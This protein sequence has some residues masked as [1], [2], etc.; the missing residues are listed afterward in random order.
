[1]NWFQLRASFTALRT[2]N[3]S[4][5]RLVACAMLLASACATT[6]AQAQLVDPF[7]WM[8][9][10]A[11]Y[12]SVVNG[13]KLYVGGQ[14]QH[15]GPY[16]G[17]FVAID[18]ISG[19]GLGGWPR[20]NG[21]GPIAVVSDD[22][23]GWYIAGG[24]TNVNG[25]RR[26]NLAHIRADR[27][28]DAWDP[29]P[30]GLVNAIAKNGNVIYVAG[31]FQN[32]GGLARAGVAALD[33]TT[34]AA[35]TWN[36]TV[37][38]PPSTFM[39][40]LALRGNTVYLSGSFVTM[41]GQPRHHLAAVDATTGAVTGWNPGVGGSPAVAFM[42]L[43]AGAVVY[44]AGQFSSAGGQPRANIAALDTTLG[45]ATAWNPG[46]DDYVQAIA[47]GG[48]KVY[49]GG[50]FQNAGGAPRSYVA[51]IDASTGA[52]T[53]WNPA[54]F[55]A[56]NG[57]WGSA[58]DNEIY[59]LAA[60]GGVVYV[61]GDFTDIGGQK[62]SGLAAVDTTL[63]G[64]T[65]WDPECNVGPATI[66]VSGGIVYAGGGFSTVG[67]LP[68]NC[69]AAFDLNSGAPT[70]WN[71]GADSTVRAL[72][73][74]GPSLYAGG[75]FSSL[76]GQPRS[77]VGAVDTTSAL[78]TSWNPGTDGEVDAMSINGA[79][80]VIGGAF[81]H[82]AGVSHAYVAG[83]DAAG[84]LRS[85]D[86][87]VSGGPVL[88]MAEA[89]RRL[90]LGGLFR[91]VNST[92]R[93]FLAEVDAGTG[94]LQTWNPMGGGE[95]DALLLTGN[96]VYTGGKFGFVG[97]Q[98]LNG[99]AAI[100]ATSGLPTAWDPL[101]TGTAAYFEPAGAF[102]VT[103]ST[104]YVGGLFTGIGGQPRASVAALNANTAAATSWN[105]QLGGGS[106]QE[107]QTL[108]HA[109][110]SVIV[111][112]NGFYMDSVS[113]HG[114]MRMLPADVI[115]PTASVLSPNGGEFW[116]IG[117]A[118][119]LTWNASDNFGIQSVDV[120]LSRTGPFGPWELIEAGS[121]N[122]GSYPWTVAGATS[123]GLCYIRVDARDW[124]GNITSAKS[125]AGFTIAP[126]STGVSP[127][128]NAVLEL[129]PPAPNPARGM[130]LLTFAL[131]H[132]MR[133]RLSVYDIQGREVAVMSDGTREAGRYTVP[134]D[135]R[136]RRPGLYFVRLKVDGA[137]LKQ[138]LFV[139]R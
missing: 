47:A 3:V 6:R 62:R 29:E 106:V 87:G 126:A 115:P 59:A 80:V 128:S 67:M 26:T 55:S 107:V 125:A 68:R 48:N 130:S 52:A 92:S 38:L 25:V 113:V 111:G 64:A 124:A 13:N 137:D 104:V 127:A 2:P 98:T 103:D 120:Y 60:S 1:V 129:A 42:L 50:N 36:P 28:L 102:T 85:W 78:A 4:R 116:Q 74:I 97:A 79:S 19:V 18:S 44:A 37:G 10:G 133:A 136:A 34:G 46:A 108:A 5:L 93:D 134:L 76:G 88:A 16:T 12:S 65:T 135:L 22:A 32:V 123:P 122:S 119:A 90:Y 77:Y 101:A 82:V 75:D 43:P 11:A 30:D 86:P 118:V 139:L 31:R 33:A 54:P 61:G 84:A 81:T 23:G 39:F 91:Y 8:L 100:D 70:T 94:V 96:T 132:R 89:G 99:I 40:T 83:F 110:S 21:G 72:E 7:F 105:A 14:F 57:V 66:A 49:I 41:G 138:K 27:T 114:L 109:G 73:V 95:V 117:D 45:N 112:G 58:Y 71:P 69:L 20:V 17:G 53:A 24:F 121:L 56:H 9:D 63:G 15:V 35:T 51:A 131:P